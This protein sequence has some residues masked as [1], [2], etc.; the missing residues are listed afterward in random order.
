MRRL[1]WIALLPCL[2]PTGLPGAPLAVVQVVREGL[3]P[4]EDADRHYRLEGDGVSGL[5]PGQVVYALPSRLD[6]FP[7]APGPDYVI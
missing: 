6:I 4:Y 5:R 2:L 3:P 1:L 7:G